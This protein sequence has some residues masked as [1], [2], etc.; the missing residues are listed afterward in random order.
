MTGF[1]VADFEALAAGSDL[2]AQ[3]QVR[4]SYWPVNYYLGDPNVINAAPLP[5]SGVKFSVLAKG[6]GELRASLQISDPDVRAMKPWELVV[7]RKTGLV[8]VRSS[9]LSDDDDEVHTVE[10]HGVVWEAPVS[11]ETGRMEIVART[12]EY[13]WA[14]RLITGPVAGGDLVFAQSDRTF[15]VQALLNPVQFSQAGPVAIT[16]SAVAAVD[17][18]SLDRV[19]ILTTELGEFLVGN[20]VRVKDSLG[21]Y[22]TNTA[23]TTDLFYVTALILSGGV[24][25]VVFTPSLASLSLTGDTI[26]AV[27]LFPGWITVDPP[28]IPTG[29]LHDLTYARDQ[30]TNLLEAHQDRSN[31][32]DG[33][34]WYTVTRVLVGDDAYQA[35]SY[36]VQFVMGYPRLGR[37]YGIDDIPR[38]S[39]YIDGRGNVLSSKAVYNGSGVRNIL[40]GQGAGYD[41]AALRV[42]TTNQ[43]DW[44]NGFLITEGK[45]SNP[46]VSVAST[47]QQYT[48]AAMVKSYA[49]EQFLDGVTV[50]GDLPPYFGT[51]GIGDDALY[52]TDSW[53]NPDRPDGTRDLTYL[54]RIMGWTVTPPEGTNSE[55]IELTL[56]GGG[57]GTDSG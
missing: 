6:V 18:G 47:L 12:I 44:D 34:D 35:S 20:Y 52:T 28:T 40:W 42:I 22:R 3:Q 2:P 53:G 45:Y 39:R 7:P 57:E 8:V 46:D 24:S 32:D 41:S 27:K 37:E 31:V 17:A 14:Q 1:E 55:T 48:N 21:N 50:R 4:Y 30:Q 51:Y 29:K 10:W 54:T 38:F 9:R 16:G 19:V 26:E 49:G 36:R 5:L 23:G 11:D 13:A 25:A 33:Y 15:I 56:I 43:T